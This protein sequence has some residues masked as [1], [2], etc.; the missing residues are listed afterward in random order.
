MDF[1]FIVQVTYG[2]LDVMVH[3]TIIMLENLVI[4]GVLLHAK[5][6]IVIRG[7]SETSRV[8]DLHELIL[9]PT[10][11]PVNYGDVPS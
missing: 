3:V 8:P 1:T 2:V 11:V 9:F 10:P 5:Y 7:I 4:T 6:P